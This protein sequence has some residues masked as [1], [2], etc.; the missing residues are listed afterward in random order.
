MPSVPPT[1]ARNA[2]ALAI[3]LS[4][5]ECAAFGDDEESALIA[6]L[7]SLLSDF[8]TDEDSFS[9]VTCAAVVDA[10]RRRALARGTHALPSALPP[11]RSILSV[12]SDAR[13][14]LSVL[15]ERSS[16]AT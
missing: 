10:R 3:T 2:V 15:S 1:T 4:G 8:G 14:R 16:T 11:A 13:S 5:I 6:A 12:L 7:A 9:S